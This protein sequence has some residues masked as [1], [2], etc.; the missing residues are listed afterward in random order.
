LNFIPTEEI[1]HNNDLYFLTIDILYTVE[2]E[3]FLLHPSRA[4]T[5]RFIDD[6][7]LIVTDASKHDTECGA[8]SV[9]ENWTAKN[10]RYVVTCDPRIHGIYQ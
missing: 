8:I 4:A 3:T 7:K 9:K 6:V 1:W 5:F 2:V 10:Q